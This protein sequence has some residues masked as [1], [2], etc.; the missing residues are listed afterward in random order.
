MILV[1]VVVQV[2][3]TESEEAAKTNDNLQGGAHRIAFRL[4]QDDDLRANGQSII[5]TI[6]CSGS[7]L[8][9]GSSRLD[10][11]LDRNS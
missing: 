8:E 9:T 3:E 4:H 5:T 7:T 6:Y 11:K 2:E 1:V 10:R